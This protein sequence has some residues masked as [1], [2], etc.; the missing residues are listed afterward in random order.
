MSDDERWHGRTAAEWEMAYVAERQARYHLAEERDRYQTA[1]ALLRGHVT[2][3]E[4][5]KL[6]NDALGARD[7]NDDPIHG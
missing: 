3:D 1:L 6:I 5:W 4:G 7:E 2:D